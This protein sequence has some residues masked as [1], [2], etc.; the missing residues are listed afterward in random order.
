MIHLQA[1]E[2]RLAAANEAFAAAKSTYDRSRETVTRTNL[3][4]DT[5]NVTELLSSPKFGAKLNKTKYCV[6]L[7]YEQNIKF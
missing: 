3:V 5:F 7:D 1:E 2:E 6:P 4:V